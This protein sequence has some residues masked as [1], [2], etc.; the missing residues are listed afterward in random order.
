MEVRFQEG[1]TGFTTIPITGT[2]KGTAVD[3]GTSP[4]SPTGVR[5][6]IGGVSGDAAIVEGHGSSNTEVVSGT[7][8]GNIE[9]V[10]TLGNVSTCT[11]ILM[12]LTRRVP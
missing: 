3:M 7:A 8:S 11:K 5:V 9:F 6:S 4:P 10:D 2:I 1:S 12:D